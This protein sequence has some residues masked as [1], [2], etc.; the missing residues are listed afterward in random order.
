MV[1]K[2]ILHVYDLDKFTPPFID[3]VEENFG[4]DEHCFWLNGDH[5]L[6]P[7]KQAGYS[8]KLG[9]SKLSVIVGYLKLIYLLSSSRKIILHGLF[10]QIVT[11]ILFMMPWLAKRCYWIIWGGDLYVYK[12][13]DRDLKWRAREFFR[14][15]VIRNMGYVVTSIDGDYNKAVEWYKCR[16]KRICYFTYPTSLFFDKKISKKKS[17]Q[18]NILVG[19]SSDP[20]NN[21]EFIFD[22]I[23]FALP[24]DFKIYVPLT[25]GDMEYR[26]KIISKGKRVFGS[27]FVPITEHMLLSD[28]NDFLSK[29]DVA[30]FAHERQQAMSNIRTL[31]GLGK[32]VY[33]NPSSSGYEQLKNLGVRVFDIY[34]SIELNPDFDGSEYNRNI[35]SRVYSR[36]SLIKNLKDLFYES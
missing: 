19:N 8:V 35:I 9:K 21:H 36:E 24:D 13:G 30:L 14:R 15:Y 2:K 20:S 26:K 18:V 1:K 32:K 3:F 16:S 27:A 29:I 10:N 33:M 12:Y 22:I 31:I 6:Y 28:Y 23:N 11:V 17:S 25:Y 4:L 5:D 34:E 7:V